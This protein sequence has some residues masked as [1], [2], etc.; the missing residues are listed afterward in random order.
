MTDEDILELFWKRIERALSE[1]RRKY[2][3]YVR[4]AAMNILGSREDAREVENDV[5][6]D[7]WNTIPPR[8]PLP[9]APYLGMLSRRGAIDRLRADSRRKRGSGQYRLTLDELRECAGDDGRALD[10]RLALRQT[11]D[12]FLSG[13]SERDRDIFLRR[14]WYYDSV[15]EISRRFG[16]TQGKVKSILFRMR[17]ALK[18]R[19]EREGYTP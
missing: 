13:L 7:A 2:G 10:D 12:A 15:P 17:E 1:C 19:L 9:L 4:T 3:A 11:L 18:K 5:Y 6:L 16:C 8:R 14:Y